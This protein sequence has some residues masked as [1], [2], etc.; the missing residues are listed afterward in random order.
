M[1]EENEVEWKKNEKYSILS[2]Y[3]NCLEM[4]PI[5]YSE[6]ILI[7]VGVKGPLNPAETSLGRVCEQPLSRNCELRT[8]W[9]EKGKR[10]IALD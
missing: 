6:L 8:K 9:K 3:S 4:N 1:K 7:I 2:S 10:T 5:V